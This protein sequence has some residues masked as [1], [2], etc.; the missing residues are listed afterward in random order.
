VER[1][2][3]VKEVWAE[4]SQEEAAAAVWWAG[5]SRALCVERGARAFSSEEGASP[6]AEES[7]GV[8]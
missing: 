2:R 3:Q 5:W 6:G 4:A 7:V 1:E 8:E